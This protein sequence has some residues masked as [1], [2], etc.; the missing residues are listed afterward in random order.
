MLRQ[1]CCKAEGARGGRVRS[2]VTGLAQGLDD[3]MR[4]KLARL[5]LALPRWLFVTLD[6]TIHTL[7][8]AVLLGELVRRKQRVHPL[9]EP[10]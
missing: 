6:H 5:G 4:K 7:P 2:A 9:A 1:V 10:A 8:V 3:N